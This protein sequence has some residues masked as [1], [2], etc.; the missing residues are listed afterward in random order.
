[1]IWGVCSG[2]APNDYAKWC[3]QCLDVAKVDLGGET[4][5][6]FDDRMEL[7]NGC[8]WLYHFVSFY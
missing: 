4:I 8:I 3:E 2:G 6:Y 7:Y 1:M 5:S